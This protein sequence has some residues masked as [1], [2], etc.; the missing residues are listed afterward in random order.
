VDPRT[1]QPLDTPTLLG[2]VA[3]TGRVVITDESHSNCGVAAGLAAIVAEQ[4][5]DALRAPIRRV[6]TLDAP[7]PYARTLEEAITPS[8]ARIVAAVR[9]LLR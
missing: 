4:A 6:S 9:D 8:I 2:S 7:V 5:F 3:R 1:L